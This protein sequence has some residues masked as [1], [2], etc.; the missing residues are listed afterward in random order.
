MYIFSHVQTSRREKDQCSRFNQRLKGPTIT[1]PRVSKVQEHLTDEER[2]IVKELG[3]VRKG[4]LYFEKLKRVASVMVYLT[5]PV[6]PGESKKEEQKRKRTDKD[7]RAHYMR[8]GTDW[9][10]RK[11]R[12]STQVFTLKAFYSLKTNL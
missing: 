2:A 10:T 4:E 6:K 8:K 3:K 9:Y 1:M 12:E 7:T 5:Q 11:G